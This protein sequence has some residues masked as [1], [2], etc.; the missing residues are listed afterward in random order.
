PLSSVFSEERGAEGWCGL[1]SENTEARGVE[2][3]WG[4]FVLVVPTV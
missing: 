3:C 2:E 1:D 4:L